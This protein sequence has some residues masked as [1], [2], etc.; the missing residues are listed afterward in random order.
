M[1]QEPRSNPDSDSAKIGRRIRQLRDQRGWT[2]IRLAHKT[3]LALAT[4]SRLEQGTYEDQR[5][6]T[7]R[8]IADAFEVQV[9]DLLTEPNGEPAGKAAS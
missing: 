7:L 9:A 3:G 4:I 8:T 5:L 1:T 2:Q 6:S